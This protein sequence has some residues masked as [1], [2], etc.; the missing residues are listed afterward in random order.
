MSEEPKLKLTHFAEDNRDAAN[1]PISHTLCCNGDY[2]SQTVF[3]GNTQMSQTK[4]EELKEYLNRGAEWW[5]QP[6]ASEILY[7]A[8]AL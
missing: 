6:V 3:I 2:K 7:Q 4:H 5:H 1:W 8:Q